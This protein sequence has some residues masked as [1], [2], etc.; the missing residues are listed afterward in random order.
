[1]DLDQ[2]VHAPA[3]RRILELGGQHVIDGGHD[4]QDAVGAPGA[5]LGHLIGV[6]EEILAQHRQIA[7]R[8]RRAQETGRA[9]KARGVGQHRQAGRAAGLIGAGQRRRVEIGPDQ[10]LRRARLLDLG[11]QRVT[12]RRV[13]GKRA[14]K[15]AHGRRGARLVLEAGQRAGGPGGGDF[16]QL[17]AADALEDVHGGL[18]ALRGRERKGRPS[19]SAPRPA[20][21]ARRSPG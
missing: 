7:G 5:R 15:A 16:V 10:T 4:D 6:K 14:G 18:I 1:M 17:V 3:D 2:H 21:P 19:R 11:D 12:G 8:A 9:L 13:V 20:R